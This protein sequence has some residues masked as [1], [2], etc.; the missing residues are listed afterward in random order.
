MTETNVTSSGRAEPVQVELSIECSI[1]QCSTFASKTKKSYQNREGS[2]VH[3]RKAIGF[4]LRFV[5]IGDGDPR[6][7]LLH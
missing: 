3:G 2:G 5:T 4:N 1:D 7:R 6:N